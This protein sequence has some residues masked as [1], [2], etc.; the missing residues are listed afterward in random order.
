MSGDTGDQEQPSE[1]AASTPVAER[2]HRWHWFAG[3]MHQF[4]DEN[5]VVL[6]AT[7]TEVERGETLAEL[8]R[9]QDRLDAMVGTLVADDPPMAITQLRARTNLTAATARRVSRRATALEAHPEVKTAL[10]GGEIHT[11]QA[12]VITRVV[13]KLP[14]EVSHL[15]AEAREVMLEL[16]LDHDAQTL[17]AMGNH[18][19]HVVAPDRADEILAKQLEKEEL[20]ARKGA[21]LK[22]YRDGHGSLFGKFKIPELSGHILETL[23]HAVANPGRPEPIDRNNK[24]LPEIK[25]QALCELLETIKTKDLPQTGG[26]TVSVIVTMTLDT[27]TGGLTAAGVLGTDRALSPGEARRLAARHGVIPVVLGEKSEILDLGRRRRYATKSQRLALA[28]RQGGYCNT[29]GC[30]IPAASCDA[31]HRTDWAKGGRT[32]LDDLELLC[33]REHHGHHHGISYP[34]RT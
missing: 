20:D 27:L 2:S 29:V 9:L 3:R 21:Y 23:L 32:D 10:A 5:P 19:I 16:A 13:D 22:T 6:T 14:A 24:D 18:L 11:D 1:T 26:T 8:T 25:G 12:E 7:M 28:L 31:N 4:L 30:D 34:R 33:P 17:K 15:K